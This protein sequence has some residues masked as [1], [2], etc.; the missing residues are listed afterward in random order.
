MLSVTDDNGSPFAGLKRADVNLTALFAPSIAN[1][2][3]GG[4]P[5]AFE[6]V[7]VS[8]W[9]LPRTEGFY[10]VGMK[11]TA[12]SGRWIGG[13]YVVGFIIE[14]KTG[15]P[16]LGGGSIRPRVTHAGQTIVDFTV[17]GD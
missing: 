4:V 11:P 2:E 16:T 1:A 6:V 14:K 8:D 3:G 15:G 13:R 10:L 9:G 7:S 17:T 5:T 12:P